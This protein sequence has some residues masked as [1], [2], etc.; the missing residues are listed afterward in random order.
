ME[1]AYR[2][3]GIPANDAGVTFEFDQNRGNISLSLH[4]TIMMISLY[5]YLFIILGT[6]QLHSNVTIGKHSE[7]VSSITALNS[8][9]LLESD[10]LLWQWFYDSETSEHLICVCVEFNSANFKRKGRQTKTHKNF[11]VAWALSQECIYEQKINIATK[12]ISKSVILEHAYPYDP[13]DIKNEGIV[14]SYVR[15]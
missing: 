6:L 1:H 3:I 7:I 10:R 12:S 9:R 14:T 8:K 15:F 2:Y 4:I 11:L 13:S 5:H